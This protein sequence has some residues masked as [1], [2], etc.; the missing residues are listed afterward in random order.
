MFQ[1]RLIFF[2]WLH[3]LYSSHIKLCGGYSW[4]LGPLHRNSGVGLY[5]MVSEFL[6]RRLGKHHLSPEIRSE[7]TVGL[8]NGIKKLPRVVVQPLAE[9]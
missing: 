9:V 8:G 1:K 2:F 5:K 4:S 6:I 7:I 3:S